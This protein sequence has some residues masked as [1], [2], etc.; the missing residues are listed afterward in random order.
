MP[1]ESIAEIIREQVS[2][3]I[4]KD[5]LELATLPEVALQQFNTVPIKKL[6]W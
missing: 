4:A 2:D 6:S 3:A 1:V 5:E